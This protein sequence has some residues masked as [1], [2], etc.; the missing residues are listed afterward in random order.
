MMAARFSFIIGLAFVAT[1]TLAPAAPARADHCSGAL[2]DT[3][4]SRLRAIEAEQPATTTDYVRRSRELASLLAEPN[5]TLWRGTTDACPGDNRQ[6]ELQTVARQ[7]VFV[8]WGKMIALGAVDGPIFP[9]PYRRECSRFDGSSL[10]LDFIRAWVGRLNDGGAGFSRAEMWR[11]LGNESLFTHVEQLA[12]DRATRLKITLLPSLDS[13]DDGWL[14]ANEA[15]RT[16]FAAALPRG[17]RCG[18]LDG[19]W[20]L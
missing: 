18:T 11:A 4:A 1:A 17:T 12:R 2:F 19:L 10:Q 16:R 15:A 5:S 6:T 7:R 8:L 20:G 13:D 9:A 3:V 14:E